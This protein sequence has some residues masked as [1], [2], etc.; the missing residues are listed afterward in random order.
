MKLSFCA[1]PT[2]NAPIMKESNLTQHTKGRLHI[3]VQAGDFSI[4]S[5]SQRLKQLA[6]SKTEVGAIVTFTG[7]VRAYSSQQAIT[8]L[9]LEHYPGMT[10][11][12]L[13]EIAVD[14]MNR[15]PLLCV[16]IIHRIGR[17]SPGAQIVFV[18]VGSMHRKAA[19]ESC[20]FIMDVLKTKATFWKKEHF[21]NSH[22]WVDVKES[23][24]QNAQRWTP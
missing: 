15:W 10:E 8:A 19:F 9:T 22:R 23:D 3:S 20:E 5:E 18:G 16:S 7:T 17:L 21:N 2:N 1:L 11:K 24:I 13:K 4:D 12:Q 14:A 6:N